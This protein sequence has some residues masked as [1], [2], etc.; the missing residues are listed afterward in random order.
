MSPRILVTLQIVTLTLIVT[1]TKI[2][3]LFWPHENVTIM[4]GYSILN[5]LSVKTIQ[6]KFALV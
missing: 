1:I 4:S 6:L 2:V 5:F 3:T